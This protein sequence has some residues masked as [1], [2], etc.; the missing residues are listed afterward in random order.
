MNER[1]PLIERRGR[2]SRKWVASYESVEEN[3]TLIRHRAAALKLID[4]RAGCSIF[5][6]STRRS[7]LSFFYIHLG[8]VDHR[9]HDPFFGLGI[10]NM[11]SKI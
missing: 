8:N 4:N 5:V 7:D 6:F 1:T 10:P 2:K 3:H 9:K 11:W